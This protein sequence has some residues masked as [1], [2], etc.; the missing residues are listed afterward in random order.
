VVSE[1]RA[2]WATYRLRDCFEFIVEAGVIRWFEMGR[3]RNSTY[4]VT[5]SEFPAKK[6][7]NTHNLRTLS[8]SSGRPI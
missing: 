8:R 3:D 4:G 7:S 6:G 2:S 5:T 1:R